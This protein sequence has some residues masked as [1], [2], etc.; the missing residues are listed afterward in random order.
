MLSP[1]WVWLRSGGGGVLLLGSVAGGIVAVGI[2]AVGVVGVPGGWWP[3]QKVRSRIE[4]KNTLAHL[5]KVDDC[6]ELRLHRFLVC[7]GMGNHFQYSRLRSALQLL[8]CGLVLRRRLREAGEQ[9]GSSSRRDGFF[10]CYGFAS[11]FI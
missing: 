2:F 7:S 4:S 11:F 3:H 10:F 1:G 5:V 8:G 9:V 6:S